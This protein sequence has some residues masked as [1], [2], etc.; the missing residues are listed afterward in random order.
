MAIEGK[1]ATPPFEGG[2]GVVRDVS[3]ANWKDKARRSLPPHSIDRDLRLACQTKVLGDI[4]VTKY[5][6][7]WGQGEE[8]VWGSE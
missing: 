1:D 4:S 6:G 8:V 3:P 5:N 7:F 2:A